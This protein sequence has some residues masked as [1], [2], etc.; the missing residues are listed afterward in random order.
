M[1]QIVDVNTGEVK[2]DSRDVILRSSPLGSCVAVVACGIEN[3]VAG[4]AHVMLPGKAPKHKIAE[5]KLRYAA[6]AI[7][8]LLDMMSKAGC[9]KDQICFA[10]VGGGNVLKRDDDTIC[11]NNID[12]VEKLLAAEKLYVAARAVGG[13]LR[14]VA[15]IDVMRG[16]VSYFEGDAGETVLLRVY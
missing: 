16:T 13:T 5:K 8:E 2:V 12:S 11:Q 9:E 1:R 3:R 4:M 10:L 6:D 15:S 7:A 14:R